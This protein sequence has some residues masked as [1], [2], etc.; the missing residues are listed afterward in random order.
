M[1]IRIRTETSNLILPLPSSLIWNRLS[2]RLFAAGL[3][4]AGASVT[5]EQMQHLVTAL[6]QYRRAHRNWVL[7]QAHTADGTDVEVRL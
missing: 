5:D 1:R 6:R 2:G 3:R 7:I 4:Q